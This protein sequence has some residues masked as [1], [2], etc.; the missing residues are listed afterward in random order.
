MSATTRTT[1]VAVFTSQGCKHCRRAKG[2]LK[3]K[4]I[5]FEE[6]D[7]TRT[8]EPLAS[9]SSV[10]VAAGDGTTTVLKAI[11]EYTGRRTVPQVFIAE[12]CIGGADELFGLEETGELGRLLREAEERGQ[13]P[14]PDAV[15]A[16]VSTARDEECASASDDNDDGFDWVRHGELREI[17]KAV[18]AARAKSGSGATLSGA[19]LV[20]LL[21]RETTTTEEEARYLAQELLRN[22]VLAS[23]SS[24]ESDFRADASSSYYFPA[25]LSSDVYNGAFLWPKAARPASVVADDLR[26]RILNLYESF[27]SP[28]GRAV[29][30]AG[31][32]ASE[33]FADYVRATGELQEVDLRALARDERVA[34]FVNIYNALVVHATA[35]E[36]PPTSVL[37]RAQFFSKI[38]Y[39][40]GGM[41]FSCDDMEH[42]V[43]RGNA[44]SPGSV[45]ALV[46]LRCLASRT[47]AARDDPRLA[48]VIEDV[49]PRIHFALV[50]GAKSCPPIRVYSAANLEEGLAGAAEAF[51]ES[52]VVVDAASA[53]VTLSRIFK[54]YGRD[55]AP[56]TEGLLDRIFAFRENDDLRNLI[57][58]QGGSSQGG[59]IK[60]KYAEYNWDV[61]SK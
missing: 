32:G 53:T 17:G 47:F 36:G 10:A 59:R 52:E 60:V 3:E 12:T 56:T 39:C 28:D 35:A 19:T 61:N 4:N 31:L 29:D 5:P 55:F 23:S 57:E 41:T 26:Q 27:L 7:V 54:W 37:K 44:V 16:F 33:A 22:R 51:C 40:I 21:R 15:E 24:A 9:S 18:S 48:L 46:G 25:T 34:F 43:L 8:L 30:Y 13:K 49:D 58:A 11:Q 42:G 2:F 45:L 38:K 20:A 14:L 50:C 1:R 6:V